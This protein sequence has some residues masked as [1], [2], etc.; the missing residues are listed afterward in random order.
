MELEIKE[1]CSLVAKESLAILN[2]F[3]LHNDGQIKR[4]TRKTK[5]DRIYEAVGRQLK[6]DF[7]A[8]RICS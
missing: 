4:K 6:E 2:F 3:L 1:R 8:L 7:K 5:K